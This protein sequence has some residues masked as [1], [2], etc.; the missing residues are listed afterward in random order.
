MTIKMSFLFRKQEKKNHR[1][2]NSCLRL[3]Q[4]KVDSITLERKKKD[5]NVY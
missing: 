4:L 1:A 3:N 5:N 2:E